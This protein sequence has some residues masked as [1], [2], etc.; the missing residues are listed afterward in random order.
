MVLVKE[1]SDRLHSGNRR[2]G[3]RTTTVRFYGGERLGSTPN[4]RIR[5]I[6][7]QGGG[8][9]GQGLWAA[10]VFLR[11]YLT[12][13][14]YLRKQNTMMP[15]TALRGL[16]AFWRELLSTVGSSLSCRSAVLMGEGQRICNTESEPRG[17]HFK[18]YSLLYYSVLKSE[19]NIFKIETK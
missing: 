18:S 7:S 4:T 1:R 19:K 2:D 15:V 17:C 3:W 12:A 8:W 16:R 13:S 14:S 11:K 10:R 6:H 9:W 5:G